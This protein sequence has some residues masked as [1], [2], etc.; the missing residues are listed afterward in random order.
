M[1]ACTKKVG[2]DD[3]LI[4]EGAEALEVLIANARPP[5]QD[6]QPAA[7]KEPQS[8]KLVKLALQKA[9]LFH[10]QTP[11]ARI[12]TAT[13][14]RIYKCASRAFRRWLA[15]ILHETEGKAANAAALADAI[16]IIEALACFENPRY[17]LH[18]RVARLDDAIWYDLSDERRRAIRVSPDGW[19]IVERPPILFVHYEHHKAQVEPVPG[20]EINQLF[21]VLPAVE[22]GSKLLLLTWLVGA[23]IPDIPHP[24]P[25]LH[26]P[27]GAG[28]SSTFRV[29]RRLI[30]P[31][32]LEVMSLPR[33]RNEFVQIL[34]HHWLSPFDN[35]D[36]LQP[37]QSDIMC[38]AVTGEGH[39]RRQLYTDDED[40]IYSFKRCVGLNGIN[41]AATRADLLDR[42]ILIGLERI[43]STQRR[44]ET[45]LDAAFQ[46]ARA[47]ILGGILDTLS[48]AMKLK[49]TIEL[50]NYPRM[51]DFARWGCAIALALG[52]SAEEFLEAYNRNYQMQNNEVLDGHAVATTIV[53]LM[54][55]RTGWQGEPGELL[56]KLET[57]AESLKINTHS[58]S[59]PKQPNVLTRRINEVKTNLKEAGLVMK[60]APGGTRGRRRVWTIIKCSENTVG[61]VGTV[62][63]P[64]KSLKN[65]NPI[66]DGMP[67]I[68]KTPSAVSSVAKSIKNNDADDAYGADGA[69]G[70]FPASNEDEQWEELII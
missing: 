67:T 10:D 3:F 9:E 39:S 65:N 63:T 27:Q 25:V 53:A 23:F 49:P 22:E 34:N 29:L 40:I 62:G 31:S 57:M 56:T 13:D 11:Y 24:V 61:S 8:S 18:N 46:E 12:K 54:E 69:D 50:S 36:I 35:V 51:A 66:A 6:Q 19:E 17:E 58:R 59:W 48:L 52:F 43:D 47:Q 41:I 38:R 16:N 33:D 42:S 68:K 64:P 28:K 30:D 20:G 7:G 14:T 2:L 26:G 1:T 45:D 15:Q 44:E 60:Q 4:A 32:I 70:N 5:Q 55:G 37:W 21:E